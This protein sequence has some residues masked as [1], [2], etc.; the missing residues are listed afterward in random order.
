MSRIWWGIVIILIGLW[1]WVDKLGLPE[2]YHFNRNWPVLIVLLGIAII[3]RTVSRR[4]RI[5]STNPDVLKDLEQGKI[6]AQEAAER[7]KK[8]QGGCCHD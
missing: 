2:I 5:R 4:P 6:T 7:L 8:Q 3:V 1:I